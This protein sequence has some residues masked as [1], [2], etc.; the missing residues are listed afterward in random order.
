M[1]FGMASLSVSPVLNYFPGSNVRQL[2]AMR[3]CLTILFSKVYHKSQNLVKIFS[4]FKVHFFG[5]FFVR[6]SF[7]QILKT[8]FS[9]FFFAK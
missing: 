7:R 4:L 8:H 9:G 2:S 3:V 5:F 6:I 1:H